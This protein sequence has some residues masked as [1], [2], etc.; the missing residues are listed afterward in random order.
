MRR[1]QRRQ[2]EP[3]NTKAGA[4]RD[5]QTLGINRNTREDPEFFLGGGAALRDRMA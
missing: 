1:T 5:N 3:S 4:A 2:C